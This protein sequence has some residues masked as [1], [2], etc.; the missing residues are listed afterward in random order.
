SEI[1]LKNNP[2]HCRSI[3]VCRGLVDFSIE[4]AGNLL[5]L[6]S[7]NW[8]RSPGSDNLGSDEARA[9]QPGY[10]ATLVA[11]LNETVRPGDSVVIVGSGFGVTAVVAGL[12]AGPSGT[13]QCFEGSKE[14]V[15]F[16]QKTVVRNKITNISVHHAV[17]AKSIFVFGSGSHVGTVMPPS[18]LPPCN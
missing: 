7:R 12:R 15:R 18:Q 11:G 5:C 3:L 6:E 14:Y 4:Y 17:V 9:D 8:G 10:E 13:V 1:F 16:T 2:M